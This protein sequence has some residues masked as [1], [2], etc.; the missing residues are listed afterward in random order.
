MLLPFSTAF[1][2]CAKI[3]RVYPFALL[4]VLKALAEWKQLESNQTTHSFAWIFH[5]KN[6]EWCNMFFPGTLWNSITNI[7]M[8]QVIQDTKQQANERIMN[9]Q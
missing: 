5:I 1:R 4:I 2:F 8:P 9:L 7:S 3:Y 6:N